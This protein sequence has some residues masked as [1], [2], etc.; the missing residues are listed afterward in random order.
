MS[1][2]DDQLLPR[3]RP[4][5]ETLPPDEPLPHSPEN[6]RAGHRAPPPPGPHAT[7]AVPPDPWDAL[8]L[9]EHGAPD[10]VGRTLESVDEAL[11]LL[12]GLV[13]RDRSGPPALWFV[14]LDADDRVLPVVLP[15]PEVPL[16]ADPVV[17]SNLLHVLASVLEHDAPGGSLLVAYVRR[18]GGDRGAFEGGWSRVLQA[19][20]GRVG[21]R[22]RAE[23]ALGQDRARVLDPR[24]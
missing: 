15:I 6:A 24:W 3:P 12:L 23:A 17:A 21:V 18:G 14:V 22:I 16:V 7:P 13:G 19:E 2:D 5:R 4:H 1:S 8:R 10:A 11:A 20:A 9:P